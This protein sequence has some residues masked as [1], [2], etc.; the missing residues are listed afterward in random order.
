MAK[1]IQTEIEKLK[2]QLVYL[3]ATVQE[4][5]QKS[6]KALWE[7]NPDL[8]RQVIA[9]DKEE[10]DTIEIDVEEECLRLLALHQPVAC[11]LRFIVTVLKINNDLERIGDLAAKIADKVLLL[12][13]VDPVKFAADGMQI[14]E[15]FNAMFAKTVWMFQN[16]L[17]AFVNED[18]DLAYRVCLED[19]EVDQAKAAIRAEMEEII[20]R[21][22][23]QQVYLAK[24]ISV[25]RS[26]E[27]IADH[28]TN[29]C[30]DII[31]MAQGR[32]VRHHIIPFLNQM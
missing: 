32:I 6:I 22:P 16:T 11:D 24:L 3:G 29:I 23:A 5:L 18:T 9:T 7:K 15:M 14:P 20:M 21:D 31:Y 4:N 19:D 26:M 12:H 8:A 27:R 28:C 25:A 1:N 17:D 2:N 30:E 10:I 13:A